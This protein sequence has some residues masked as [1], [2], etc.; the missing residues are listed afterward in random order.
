MS[1]CIYEKVHVIGEFVE[2]VDAEEDFGTKQ[3]D[4]QFAEYS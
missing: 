3:V 4:K 2:V 1:V